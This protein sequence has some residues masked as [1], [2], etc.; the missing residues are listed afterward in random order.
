MIWKRISLILVIV[1]IIVII[2]AISYFFVDKES[3]ANVSNNEQ[4]ISDT[5]EI[6]VFYEVQKISSNEERIIM[7]VGAREGSFLVKK[8]NQDSIEG[9]WFEIYPVEGP[10]DM[11][12]LKTLHIGD[13]IGYVCDG[14][15]KKLTSINFLEQR[16]SFTK[17]KGEAPIGGCPV[18]LSG[19]TF[20]NTPSGNINIKELK[21]GML[22]WTSDR[23]GNR[24][25]VAISKVGKTKIH[26]AHELI[27]IVLDNGKELFVSQGHPTSDGRIFRDI[28]LGEIIDN[29][30]IKIMELIQYDQEYTYDILPEGETGFYWANGILIGSTLK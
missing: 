16:I 24:K 19:N 8:I 15:S 2:G 27:H 23:L 21:E 12:V 25:S 9:L 22:V 1:V 10:N 30:H 5:D 7:G 26:S 20:I 3:P 4:I 17:I 13:D 11:G 18:C 6:E 28:K 29:S 14:I